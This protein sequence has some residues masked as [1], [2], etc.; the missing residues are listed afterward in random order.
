MSIE[1]IALEHF[2]ELTQTEIKAST[3]VCP[4]HAVFHYFFS[5]E[6]KRYSSTT[7]SHRNCLI[8]LLKEQKLLTS[9][10]SKIW[11]NTDGHAEQ[12]RCASALYLM[13]VLSQCHLIILDIVIIATASVQ[14]TKIYTIKELVMME[15]TISNFY[16]SFI[17][18][19]SISWRFTFHM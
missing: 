16:K 5:D 4:R 9:T 8:E 15:T 17:L 14:S 18:Q 11:E 7:N 13:S 3:K 2:R 10:L 12:Y 19:K 1:V 6:I